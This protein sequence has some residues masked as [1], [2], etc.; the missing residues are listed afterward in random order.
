MLRHPIIFKD[1]AAIFKICYRHVRVESPDR[2]IVKKRLIYCFFYL[3]QL[4]SCLI[5]LCVS[6]YYALRK[7]PL[8]N[9]CPIYYATSYNF[10][11]LFFIPTFSQLI[12]DSYLHL[13]CGVHSKFIYRHVKAFFCHRDLCP[14]L[15]CGY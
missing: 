8:K 6:D 13:F 10:L 12:F 5:L 3:L 4:P 1:K 7:R 2:N 9:P 14:L 11:C 15:I